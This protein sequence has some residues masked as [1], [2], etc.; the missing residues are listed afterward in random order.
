MAELDYYRQVLEDLRAAGIEPVVTFFHSTAPRWFAE[1]G[2]WLN[3]GAPD[4]FARYC[5]TAAH[6]LGKFIGFACTINEPQVA[7][8]F[9]A[10]PMAAAYFKAADEKALSLHAM[11]ARASGS[12]R[13]VTMEYPDIK[14]MTPQLIVAHEKGFAAIKAA[15][16]HAPTGVTLSLVDFAPANE[17]SKVDELRRLAYGEWMESARRTATLSACS[18]TTRC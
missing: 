5:G 6:A 14:G 1:R 7:M 8:T 4:L 17:A 3:P 12:T 10:I 16:P 11:A 15:A 18:R 2:G 13:F 9:R